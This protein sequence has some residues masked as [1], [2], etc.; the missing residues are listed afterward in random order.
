MITAKEIAKHL[1]LPL[2]GD[3]ITIECYAQLSAPRPHSI[4]FA[5]KY[6]DDYVSL[7]NE[8]EN[9]LAIVT[10][11]YDGKLTCCHIISANPRLDFIKVLS[12]LFTQEKPKGFIHPSANIETGATIGKNVFI[13]AGCYVSAQSIVGDERIRSPDLQIGQVHW[14]LHIKAMAGR[15]LPHPAIVI[16][17]RSC[18]EAILLQHPGPDTRTLFRSLSWHPRFRVRS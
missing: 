17:R 16:F 8:C 9:I 1:Q 11:D 15:G 5:K 18:K 3:N 13:G 2:H 6:S 4:V 10:A 12:Q 7:L 14:K